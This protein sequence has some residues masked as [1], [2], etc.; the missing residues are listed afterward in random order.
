MLRR[1]TGF[2]R[3]LK[4]SPERSY[5]IRTCWAR[6]GPHSHI[7]VKLGGYFPH[8]QLAPLVP[9]PFSQSY[10]FLPLATSRFRMVPCPRTP[11]LPT[12]LCSRL[13]CLPPP[14]SP[15]LP[16]GKIVPPTPT[17]SSASHVHLNPSFLSPPFSYHP[18]ETPPSSLCRR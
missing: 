6:T 5:E 1:H 9:V 17:R 3:V 10:T 16:P 15:C 4:H 13:S 7:V 12:P 18:T 8:C 2:S 14:F 11:T